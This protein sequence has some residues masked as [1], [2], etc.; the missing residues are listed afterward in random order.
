MA[1]TRDHL[2]KILQNTDAKKAWCK[3]V[4]KHYVVKRLHFWSSPKGKAS[5]VG[6]YAATILSFGKYGS[7]KSS[8][9]ILKDCNAIKTD[10][11]AASTFQA[12][13]NLIKKLHTH[14]VEAKDGEIP[15]A[16][17]P[18]LRTDTYYAIIAMIHEILKTD[19]PVDYQNEINRIMVNLK[20]DK[21]S[22]KNHYAQG[23]SREEIYE[24]INDHLRQL[25]L[26][27]YKPIYYK[28]FE[29]YR[30]LFPTLFVPISGKFS[31]IEE[32]E[33][34][35]FKVLVEVQ[36]EQE[37]GVKSNLEDLN[38]PNQNIPY[39]LQPDFAMI[40][41][42]KEL[43]KSLGFCTK[44]ALA[45]DILEKG[46]SFH[47]LY[48]F[49][50][51]KFIADNLVE[52]KA[53]KEDVHQGTD[54]DVQSEIAYLPV[55]GGD[56]VSLPPPAETTVDYDIEVEDA[57]SDA[58]DSEGISAEQPNSDHVKPLPVLPTEAVSPPPAPEFHPARVSAIGTFAPAATTKQIKTDIPAP[59]VIEEIET[60][61]VVVSENNGST[62]QPK[63]ETRRRAGRKSH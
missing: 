59:P 14:A 22:Y 11:E 45:E 54:V 20:I 61:Q 62:E 55:D 26:L 39:Q 33:A 23:R 1:Q 57:A 56:A 42:H 37:Q 4:L 44:I 60:E 8:E 15:A 29:F 19:F 28:A 13:I 38:A 47:E 21:L 30:N 49:N 35:S 9:E 16:S 52:D 3:K 7:L 25:V 58:D 18:S 43:K 5:K 31:F 48:E 10:I 2:P 50:R 41:C 46:K 53:P 6:K 36:I 51:E 63:S 32:K 17:G 27:G 24:S 40:F 12:Y 34:R